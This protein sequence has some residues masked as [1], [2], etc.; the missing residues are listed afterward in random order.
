MGIV[1]SFLKEIPYVHVKEIDFTS[2]KGKNIKIDS[3][4]ATQHPTPC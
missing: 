4:L 1:P 3:E 2:A